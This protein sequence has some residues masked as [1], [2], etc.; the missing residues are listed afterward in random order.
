M[1]ACAR[2][3]VKFKCMN[4][5]P[6]LLTSVYW[7]AKFYIAS[8][9]G[10]LEKSVLCRPIFIIGKSFYPEAAYKLYNIP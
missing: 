2:N 6:V 1:E 9:F 10:V 7:K 5:F 4:L 8:C 3:L